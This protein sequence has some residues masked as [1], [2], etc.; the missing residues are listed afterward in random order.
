MA[1]RERQRDKHAHRPARRLSWPTVVLTGGVLLSLA[2]NLDQAQPDTWGRITAATPAAAFLVAVSMLERRNIGRPTPTPSPSP[3]VLPVPAQDDR[4]GPVPAPQ[5]VPAGPLVDYARKIA[6]DHH[7]ATGQ[8]ITRD[9]L[10]ARLGISNQL[11]SELLRQ[12]RTT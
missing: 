2:A 12:L 5:P 11:A 10:R 6:A 1:A 8:P 4:P 3:S 7:T 9:A